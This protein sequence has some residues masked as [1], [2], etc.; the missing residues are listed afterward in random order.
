[1]VGIAPSVTLAHAGLPAL[2]AK[3]ELDDLIEKAW[4]PPLVTVF[5]VNVSHEVR[6]EALLTAEEKVKVVGITA[7]L[8]M[9]K[10]S[11]DGTSDSKFPN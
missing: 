11:I 6:E 9:V 4:G 10:L 3:L 1:M 8:S 7:K 2:A 5:P